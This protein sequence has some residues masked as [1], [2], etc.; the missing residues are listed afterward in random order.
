MG[1]QRNF[2]KVVVYGS[3]YAGGIGFFHLQVY[4]LA[5]KVTGTM[6]HVRAQTKIGNNF[7]IMIYWAQ[8]CMGI[9]TAVL[10]YEKDIPHLEGKWL[11]VFLQDLCTI[12]GKIHMV[13]AWMIPAQREQDKHPMEI[14]CQSQHIPDHNIKHLNYCC[15]YL[16]I[17]CISDIASSDGIFVQQEY[18][19]PP[20]TLPKMNKKPG[21]AAPIMPRPMGLETLGENSHRNNMW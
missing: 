8:I 18:L 7:I 2:P 3:K 16:C 6:R 19:R 13:E 10:D 17:T 9:S 14:I 20:I 21:L 5:A 12:S 4:Q 15:M 1:Y 11:K